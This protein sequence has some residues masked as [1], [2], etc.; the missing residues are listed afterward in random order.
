MEQKTPST[1]QNGNNSQKTELKPQDL[2][3][4]NYLQDKDSGR[5][6]K[7]ISITRNRVICKMYFSRLSQNIAE[8]QPIPLTQDMLLRFGFEEIPHFTVG[9]GIFK[10]LGRGRRITIS[11]VGTP[12]LMVYLAEI[13]DDGKSYSD[14]NVLHNYDYDGELYAHNLQNIWHSIAKT[15]LTLK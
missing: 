8:W 10:E 2:R 4:G 14:L 1:F 6:G 3:I 12:N 11:D 13:G 7:V 15:E 5:I 9:N